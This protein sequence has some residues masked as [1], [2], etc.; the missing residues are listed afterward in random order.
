MG[1]VRCLVTGG[2]GFIGSHL[3]QKLAELGH[4]V[5]V[6][7][8]NIPDSLRNRA[9]GG[10]TYYQGDVTRLSPDFRLACDWCFHLAAL[11]DIIPSIKEPVKYHQVNVTGTINI[12]DHCV[13]L[14]VKK[15][16]YASSTSIY[17]IPKQ[18]PTLE[19]APADPRYPYALT[20]WVAEEAVMHWG[21]VYHLPVVALRITT[22]YGPGMRARGAYGSVMKVFLP[23]KANNMPYTVTGD[24][25]Q[26][27]DFIFVDDVVSA[28]V[29]AAES[30][31]SGEV[32]NVGSGQPTTLGRLI[33]LL[34]D[35]NG[36]VYLPKRPGE[37]D[38]T[39]ADISKAKRMLGW[40]PKVS[41]EEGVKV[42]LDHL[43]DWKDE[44]VW[45]PEEIREA[46]RE[47][48]RYLS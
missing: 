14:G 7:D 28:F 33:E 43:T 9:S 23:Q 6:L 13:N 41:I 24:L 48:Y 5:M 3:A 36:I 10:I 26:S 38:M 4:E 32:F 27:R 17:G 20:K 12:L 45:T 2:G 46:T 19:S 47:W 18:Y 29:Q 21:R 15:L 25:S 35:E 8:I 39:W 44:K 40:G 37:P 31:V 22:A 34:G 1:K 16:V 11:A 42:M 30:D